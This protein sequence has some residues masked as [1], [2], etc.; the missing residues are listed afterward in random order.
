[1]KEIAERIKNTRLNKGMTQQ[2]LAD[3]LGFKSRS[4]VCQI[5]NDKYEI[6]LETAKKIASALEVDADY[7]IFGDTDSAK[8]EITDLFDRLTE[9]QQQ[10]VLRFLRSMLGDRK[11]DD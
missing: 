5:E 4:A 11:E 2:Q 10:S 8:E 7:L 9:D 1:M 6:S 3:K